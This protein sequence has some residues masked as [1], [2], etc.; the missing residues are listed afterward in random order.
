MSNIKKTHETR[1]LNQGIRAGKPKGNGENSVQR[2][3]VERV[4]TSIVETGC[5][6]EKVSCS[7]V[8]IDLSATSNKG[9]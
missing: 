1:R 9:R 5:I 3:T 8:F 7:S 4:A 6:E 2:K